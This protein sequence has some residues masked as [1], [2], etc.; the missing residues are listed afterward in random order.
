MAPLWILKEETVTIR[1]LERNS[2]VVRSSAACKIANILSYCTPGQ[3]R[4]LYIKGN[5][6]HIPVVLCMKIWPS[7]FKW[8]GNWGA[9]WLQ[10]LKMRCYLPDFKRWL[11]KAARC[12]KYK[13]C[14]KSRA[15]PP[16]ISTWLLNSNWWKKKISR[17]SLWIRSHTLHFRET[18]CWK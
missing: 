16:I 4:C 8:H 9:C 11:S 5:F 13:F 2:Q 3:A 14:Y 15:V 1:H 7:S 18:T 6:I 12:L 10:Y 17:L